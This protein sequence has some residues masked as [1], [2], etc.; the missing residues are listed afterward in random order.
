MKQTTLCDCKSGKPIIGGKQAIYINTTKKGGLLRLNHANCFHS[1]TNHSICRYER[2]CRLCNSV[3]SAIGCRTSFLRL[4]S[5]MSNPIM[6]CSSNEK[7]LARP[8]LCLPT[9]PQSQTNSDN[10]LINPNRNPEPVR[11][12]HRLF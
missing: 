12:T 10:K 7:P 6:P 3:L 2:M 4:Q 9:M 1:I 11:I 5:R 8:R